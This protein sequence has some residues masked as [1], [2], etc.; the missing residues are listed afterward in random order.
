MTFFDFDFDLAF[1]LFVVAFAL[2]FDLVFEPDFAVVFCFDFET[3]L[4]RFKSLYT[5][6]VSVFFE[7]IILLL[8]CACALTAK[9]QS[10]KTIRNFFIGQLSDGL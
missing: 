2:D 6:L 5:A 3:E 9:K 10:A 4:L 7:T 1:D 8:I